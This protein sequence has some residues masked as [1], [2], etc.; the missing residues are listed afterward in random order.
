MISTRSILDKVLLTPSSTAAG[1]H[2]CI[3]KTGTCSWYSKNIANSSLTLSFYPY[4][5]KTINYTLTV[6]QGFCPQTK[7]II[8]GSNDNKNYHILDSQNREMC[9]SKYFDGTNN[10]C[11]ADRPTSSKLLY[12]KYFTFYRIRT[13]GDRGCSGAYG[14]NSFPIGHAEFYGRIK[15]E[16]GECTRYMKHSITFI[17]NIIVLI[18]HV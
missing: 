2:S 14:I 6:Q 12:P 16:K 15:K 11:N 9:T 18:T 1:D 10:V 5:F 4:A 8:E 3:L 7:W 17:A 13:P